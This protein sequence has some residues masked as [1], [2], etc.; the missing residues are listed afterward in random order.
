MLAAVLASTKAAD[1]PTGSGSRKRTTNG[2]R[3]NAKRQVSNDAHV[4]HKASLN[5]FGQV[6]DAE[7]SLQ[8]YFFVLLSSLNIL[9]ITFSYSTDRA[10]SFL[11]NLTQA[12]QLRLIDCFAL[13]TENMSSEGPS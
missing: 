1:K 12:N 9:K 5:F 11:S 13:F 7:S 8:Q 6:S 10:L 3:P 2:S 4:K